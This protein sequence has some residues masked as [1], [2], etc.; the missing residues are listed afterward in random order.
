VNREE[1]PLPIAENNSDVRDGFVA[2]DTGC[3]YTEGATKTER[4]RIPHKT[5]L[6]G[7]PVP[8][9]PSEE[10]DP[11]APVRD[12]IDYQTLLARTWIETPMVFTGVVPVKE[13]IEHYKLDDDKI[14]K[15]GE[16]MVD[17]RKEIASLVQEETKEVESDEDGT[18][19]YEFPG[20][21]QKADEIR[22]RF[23]E[24]IADVAGEEFAKNSASS[25][26]NGFLRGGRVRLRITCRTEPSSEP[27][28]RLGKNAKGA[29]SGES[30][31]QII[32]E[33]Y[34]GNGNPAGRFSGP[35]E[36]IQKMT[37]LDF[38]LGR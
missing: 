13:V 29:G 31:G 34:D 12:G 20:Y 14:A 6:P 26:D 15:L 35:A 5:K 33:F 4:S 19:V 24:R 36:N 11:F 27:G 8:R 18:V 23:L 17:A 16:I 22:R 28:D 25:L 21:P 2:S 37:M 10:D 38:G 9:E 30:G 1:R 3:E 32:L 7:K